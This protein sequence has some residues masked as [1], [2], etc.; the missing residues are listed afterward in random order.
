M[1]RYAY[2][3]TASELRR[4]SAGIK[5]A[6]DE[7]KADYDAKYMAVRSSEKVT[8]IASGHTLDDFG[9]RSDALGG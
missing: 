8:D 4:L 9:G 6:G 3:A 2:Q 5:P 7:L 1:S